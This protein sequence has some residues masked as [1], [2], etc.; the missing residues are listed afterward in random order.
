MS[1]AVISSPMR[2]GYPALPEMPVV[3]TAA[4]AAFNGLQENQ[5]KTTTGGGN[6][7]LTVPAKSRSFGLLHIAEEV[8]VLEL[9]GQ[10]PGGKMGETKVGQDQ[11][12]KASDANTLCLMRTTL[13][14]VLSKMVI[15]VPCKDETLSVI[16]SVISAI[17]SS[18]L[19][20]LVSN[21]ERGERDR[22]LYMQQVEMVKAFARQG[23]HI[24][25]IH[26]KDPAAAA[27]FKA[28]G[29]L[30]LVN[31]SDGTIRN[32]KGEGMLLAIAVAAAFSR[33]RRYIGF[34]DADN[35][36][37]SSVNEYCRAFAAG[38]AMSL[39]PDRENTM[40]RLK[41]ASKPKMR[42]GR[43]ELVAEGRCSKVVNPWLNRLLMA[44]GG[45]SGPRGMSD[46]DKDKGFITTGNAGEHAMTMD[47]ALKLRMAA[48]YAI[49]PFH[50]VDL[51][52]R[53][54]TL[55]VS[56]KAAAKQNHTAK[57]TAD[58]GSS[59]AASRAGA[60]I[61]TPKPLDKP[62]RV[63][64]VRTLNPH[65]HRSTDDDHITSMWAAG[66]GS[67]YH[68]TASYRH[69]QN[70]DGGPISKLRRELD[71]FAVERGGYDKETG[72]LPRPRVYQPLED[73]DMAMFREVLGSSLGAGSLRA[74]GF[75]GWHS[76]TI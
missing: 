46:T 69:I 63:L 10:D 12:E 64:Q 49:E 44:C 4:L 30:D 5:I 45:N 36:H 61:K 50:F 59:A 23:R 58:T 20:I 68:G 62:V 38:F 18:C 76:G 55:S 14:K 16:K 19:V 65:F 37:P 53:T 13:D 57:G 29:M 71:A 60:G 33:T 7:R 74:L 72:E 6:M 70:S 25:A 48:G 26:Q 22:D 8:R 75:V 73:M 31:P 47:L 54:Q 66:L 28:A 42:N 43:I 32:G 1:A 3:A 67:I 11:N 56:G 15:V 51:L 27:A 41:W 24:L 34:V 2:S 40:V 39:A 17:P 35:L 52:E 9:D 21:C